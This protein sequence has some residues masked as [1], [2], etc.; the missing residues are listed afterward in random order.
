MAPW[1]MPRMKAAKMNAATN[2][3]TIGADLRDP[4]ISTITPFP[5]EVK[6]G[7]QAYHPPRLVSFL[8]A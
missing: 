3:S 5:A 7:G 2:M 6:L 8:G 1:R 4:A